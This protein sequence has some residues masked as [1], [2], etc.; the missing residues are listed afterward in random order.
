MDRHRCLGR[1]CTR[2]EPL[3]PARPRRV[4]GKRAARRLVLRGV[5]P[6]RVGLSAGNRRRV[7]AP[8]SV[9]IYPQQHAEHRERSARRALPARRTR[10][11]TDRFRSAPGRWPGRLRRCGRG[12]R[13]V[14]RVGSSDDRGHG[15]GNR[16]VGMDTE[17]PVGEQPGQLAG[18][19]LRS[20][21]GRPERVAASRPPWL[22][23][24]ER[25]ARRWSPAHLSGAGCGD[26]SV[27]RDRR[28]RFQYPDPGQQ[29]GGPWTQ[30][31]DRS[32]ARRRVPD[33]AHAPGGRSDGAPS[34]PAARR[35]RP[36]RTPSRRGHV[37]GSDRVAARPR[38]LVGT[39]KRAC[40]PS[41]C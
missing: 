4:S 34:Q 13:P 8:V 19:G 16:G 31:V 38:G 25:L 21:P 28:P 5:R 3:L 27:C 39:R 35:E 18:A 22:V 20:G 15:H 2:D 30:Q 23:A 7:G 12:I 11:G 24:R 33:R 10:R 26:R 17:C 1:T 6:V 9:R 32:R 14:C 37:L 29:A 36:R 40:V 41:G